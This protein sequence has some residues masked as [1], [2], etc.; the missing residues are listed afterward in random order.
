MLGEIATSRTLTKFHDTA[1]VIANHPGLSKESMAS[2]A[3]V[4]AHYPSEASARK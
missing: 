4:T 1:Q 2:P 3:A